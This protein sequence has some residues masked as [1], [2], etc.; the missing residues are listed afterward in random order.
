MNIL[1]TYQFLNCLYSCLYYDVDSFINGLLCYCRGM[2][3]TQREFQQ[4][5]KL[6]FMS[7]II[8]HE[9]SMFEVGREI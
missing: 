2:T 3:D 4:F 8:K 5:S 7:S 6:E 1:S 9:I